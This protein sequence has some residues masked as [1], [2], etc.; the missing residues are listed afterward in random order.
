ME[1]RRWIMCLMLDIVVDSLPKRRKSKVYYDLQIQN[2][3]KTPFLCL[4]QLLESQAL[5]L[6]IFH[7]VIFKIYVNAMHLS[8]SICHQ[9]VSSPGSGICES[10]LCKLTTDLWALV[11]DMLRLNSRTVLS[12]KR[13]GNIVHSSQFINIDKIRPSS[14]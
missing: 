5:S 1:W 8:L 3:I 13:T 7:L 14:S 10:V 9:C 4:Q 2:G 11:E 6:H 12:I